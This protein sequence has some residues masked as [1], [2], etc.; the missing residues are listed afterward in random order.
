M[1]EL[2]FMEP[3]F[4]EAIWGGTRL[5][6]VF[7]Y[8]IPSSRTGECWAISAHKNGD[9]RIA[10]GTWKGQSLS[11]LWESHPEWFGA[12]AGCHKEFP[13]LVK[14][15]DAR[16]DLSIQVHPDNAYA[17]EHENG[18]LGKTECWYILDCD[19]DATIVIGH[20]AGNK[21]EVKQM[22]E[23]K[24]WKDFIREIPVSKGDF[25]QINPGCVHAIKGGTLC[26]RLSRAVI[27]HTAFMTTTGCP[28]GSPGS[29][30]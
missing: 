26:W 4:K 28:A 16:N 30:I 13:L 12:A 11:S 19:P 29:S 7:G 17:G 14:I 18:S 6:D 21:D 27:L 25:F 24:R 2:L 3:V 22:I 10:G 23:E 20:H 1:R 5:K 9:C 15:I 8:D